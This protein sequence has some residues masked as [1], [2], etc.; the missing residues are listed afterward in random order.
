LV[1]SPKAE[2]WNFARAPLQD[3]RERMPQMQ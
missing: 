1:P 3:V 2:V